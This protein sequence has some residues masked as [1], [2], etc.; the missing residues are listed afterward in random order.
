[1][2]AKTYLSQLKFL[3]ADIRR[4]KMQLAELE[5][6]ASGIKGIRYDLEKVQSSSGNPVEDSII[7]YISVKEKLSGLL[8]K[9]NEKYT[10]ITEQIDMVENVKYREILKQYF[11]EDKKLFQIADHMRYDEKYVYN[12]FESALVIFEGKIM[13]KMK[14]SK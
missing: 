10:Q 6:A 7:R 1:M 13:T 5:A 12:M 11:I 9:Y 8:L 3:K 2:K 4:V 14:H